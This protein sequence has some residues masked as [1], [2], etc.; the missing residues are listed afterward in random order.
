ME[1]MISL[2]K[3]ANMAGISQYALR[4]AVKQGFISFT[5]FDNSSNSKMWFDPLTF[6]AE[7]TEM[8]YRNRPPHDPSFGDYESED[9]EE[10]AQRNIELRT[11][12]QMEE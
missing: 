10:Q 3:A 6:A 11:L 8:R 9:E 4:K 7:I 5:C 2:K 12:L 1:K